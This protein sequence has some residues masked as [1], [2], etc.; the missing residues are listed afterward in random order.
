MAVNVEQMI[1]DFV[2]DAHSPDE[3]A[4]A[5]DLSKVMCRP[6]GR[7]QPS[8]WPPATPCAP[9]SPQGAAGRPR[10]RHPSLWPPATPCARLSPQGAAGRPRGRH[11]PVSYTHLTLPTICSV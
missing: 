1:L 11:H 7:H 6:R 5:P 3:L 10:G 2:A 9:L 8:L 4:F